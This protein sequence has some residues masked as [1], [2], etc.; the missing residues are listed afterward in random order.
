MQCARCWVYNGE[1][2]DTDSYSLWVATDANKIITQTDI[3]LKN[4]ISGI[5]E[6]YRQ[7]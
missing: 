7:L 6:K 3:K 1:N 2:T 4:V 5:E